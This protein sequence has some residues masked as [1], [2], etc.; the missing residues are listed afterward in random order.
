[1]PFSSFRSA[2][3]E[4]LQPIG[5]HR[6]P[7]CGTTLSQPRTWWYV[8][9]AARHTHRSVTEQPSQPA[10]QPATG[11]T[12]R[13]SGVCLQPIVSPPLLSIRHGT[14]WV[15]YAATGDRRWYPAARGVGAGRDGP[16]RSRDHVMCRQFWFRRTRNQTQGSAWMTNRVGL[17]FTWPHIII[18]RAWPL[19]RGAQ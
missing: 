3:A 8:C 4:M 14:T 17:G 7:G 5:Q 9:R 13:L 2:P 10:S 6:R 18:A 16:G 15:A 12:A 19:G 11:S 1:M